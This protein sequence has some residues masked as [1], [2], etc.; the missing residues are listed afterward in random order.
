MKLSISPAWS[1]PGTRAIYN[2]RQNLSSVSCLTEI[3]ALNKIPWKIFTTELFACFCFQ[4]NIICM[5]I[6][7]HLK[8]I[9][10]AAALGWCWTGL[11]P[12]QQEC[13]VTRDG[14]GASPSC[15]KSLLNSRAWQYSPSYKEEGWSLFHVLSKGPEVDGHKNST[16]GGVAHGGWK[17]CTGRSWKPSLLTP[18]IGLKPSFC[19]LSERDLWRALYSPENMH[20]RG[21]N[22]L[23]SCIFQSVTCCRNE[24]FP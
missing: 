1:I 3:Q 23:H 22:G 11:P 15:F 18:L 6:S 8:E 12:C 13:R 20:I 10:K 9:L 16:K 2:T 5:G 24:R 21:I 7:D 19:E 4:W 14:C 17:R